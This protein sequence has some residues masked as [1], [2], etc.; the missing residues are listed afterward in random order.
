[1]YITSWWNGHQIF[2]LNNDE[3]ITTIFP[4]QLAIDWMCTSSSLLFII[5][6]SWVWAK[7]SSTM[8]RNREKKFNWKWKNIIFILNTDIRII[9]IIIIFGSIFS[10]FSSLTEKSNAYRKRIWRKK[11]RFYIEKIVRR[12]R[13]KKQS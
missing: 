3:P 8:R 6:P 11:I 5:W 7:S 1:M 13:K 10:S 2:Y 4:W 9:I 12:R